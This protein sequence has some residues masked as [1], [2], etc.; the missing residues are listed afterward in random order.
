[1]VMEL[2][3]RKILI[4]DDDEVLSSLMKKQLERRGIYECDYVHSIEAAKAKVEAY[5][6]DLVLLDY[7][8]PDGSGLECFE[9]CRNAGL[10]IPTIMITANGNESVAVT[11]LKAGISDYLVKDASRAFFDL[12]PVVIQQVMDNQ[13][14]ER[15]LQ[16]QRKATESANR[17]LAIA[18]MRL[19][20]SNEAKSMV[21]GV[22]S[23][24]MKNAIH[25]ISSFV[26]L[27]EEEPLEDEVREY[28]GDIKTATNQAQRLLEELLK[29]VELQEADFKLNMEVVN[30]SELLESVI[31]FYTKMADR[32]SIRL[33]SDIEEG[34]RVNGDSVRLREVLDNL[35]SNAIKYSEPTTETVVSAWAEGDSVLISVKDQ[36]P[37]FSE[38]DMRKIYGRFQRLSARPTAGESSSGLGLSIVK[39]IM[40]LHDA[41]IDLI[42]DLG[43][44][45]EFILSLAKA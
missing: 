6:P 43:E 28:V 36:G 11:A 25:A 21:L 17:S 45:S 34:L 30:L 29:A 10:V 1:M 16:D 42:S 7:D 18:N 40:D 44:G 31:P 19:Q 8:L 33:S 38:A 5:V 3:K 20:E 14:K 39:K 32:K 24:E 35:L 12:L 27:I 37:G 2:K 4:V 9:Q 41:Q 23:H 26:S 22:A 13:A 15:E